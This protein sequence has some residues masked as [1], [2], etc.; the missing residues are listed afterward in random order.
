M[1]GPI[2]NPRKIQIVSARWV[3]AKPITDH[4]QRPRPRPIQQPRPPLNKLREPPEVL[5]VN[6]VQRQVLKAGYRRVIRVNNDR[7]AAVMLH[8]LAPQHEQPVEFLLKRV[9]V[10]LRRRQGRTPIEK[11]HE[12]A[13]NRMRLAHDPPSS[14]LR[15]VRP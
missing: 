5:S 15:S 3:A 6:P 4:V 13:C 8:C 9:P 11:D 1:L 2:P 7:N 10:A 14:Y 12:L